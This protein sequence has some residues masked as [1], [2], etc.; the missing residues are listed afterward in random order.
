MRLAILLSIS[1]CLSACEG[2]SRADDTL[3]RDDQDEMRGFRERINEAERR[4]GSDGAD[5]R[6]EWEREH[7]AA[8]EKERQLESKVDRLHKAMLAFVSEHEHLGAAG[9][10]RVDRIRNLEGLANLLVREI[11]DRV[12]RGEWVPLDEDKAPAFLASVAFYEYSWNWRNSNIT[13]SRGER[14]MFQVA[15]SSIPQTGFTEDQVA[16]DPRAC[17]TAAIYWMKTV[18]ER[19]GDTPAEGWLG[20]YATGGICG[21]A[22]DVVKMRFDMTRWLLRSIDAQS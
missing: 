6:A 22:P 4:L 5:L 17:L 21:G 20:A 18:A 2:A 19:C 12:S 14:C 10:A 9:A 15:P 8:M 11:N 3:P 1:L 7:Q 13:G 16:R